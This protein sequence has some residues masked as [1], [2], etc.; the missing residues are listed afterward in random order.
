[1]VLVISMTNITDIEYRVLRLIE[2]RKENPPSKQELQQE[3]G[4]AIED[5]LA[6]LYERG[7]IQVDFLKDRYYLTLA[8]KSVYQE[9]TDQR[10]KDTSEMHERIELRR[11][12]E[13]QNH[14]N[15]GLQIAA[16]VIA[17]LTLLIAAV[18]FFLDLG[19]NGS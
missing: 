7:L 11:K 10:A 3:F 14:L 16:I 15:W 8:G 13:R 6:I 4:A 5:T 18:Q 17:V 12:T 19:C 1:M 9:I 2:D